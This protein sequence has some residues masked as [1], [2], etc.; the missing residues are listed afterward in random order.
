MPNGKH[1]GVGHVSEGNVLD[2]LGF[3]PQATLELKLKSDIHRGILALIRRQRYT[4]RELERILDVPQPRVS[5][6]MRGKLSTLS[7]GKL[8]HYVR[9]LGGDTRV[10]VRQR[11]KES[12]RRAA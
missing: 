10:R 8:A 5:E 7:V 1:E 12:S 6:L 11:R 2:D 4:R 9:L 3:D